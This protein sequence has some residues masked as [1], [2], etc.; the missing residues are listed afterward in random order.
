MQGTVHVLNS[1]I[2]ISVYFNL[3]LCISI[4]SYSCIYKRIV[5]EKMVKDY[6]DMRDR[7]N[8]DFGTHYI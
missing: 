2:C 8:I 4:L 3:S 6:S 5:Y 1:D 7:S